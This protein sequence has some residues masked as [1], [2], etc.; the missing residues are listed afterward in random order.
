M[1]KTVGRTSAGLRDVLFDSI[2]KLRNGD[3]ES[4]EASSIAKLAAAICKTVS[5]EIEVAR[6]RLQYPEDTK[7]IVPGPM[8]LGE[9]VDKTLIKS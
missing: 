2:D 3:I 4:A 7:M 5:L 6:L 9:E 8:A 1:A